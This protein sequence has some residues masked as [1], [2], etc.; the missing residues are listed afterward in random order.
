MGKLVAGVAKGDITPPAGLV[1]AGYGSR[2]A[3]ALGTHDDL[4]VVALY[5][6]DGETEAALLTV[7]LLAADSAGV[8]RIREAASRASGVLPEKIMVAFSH[9]HGAP[10]TLL[11]G[12]ESDDPLV[13]TY[14]DMV[15]YKLAGALAE[16]KRAATP[17]RIGYGRQSCTVG[18]NRR[19]MR[20]DGKVVLGVNRE[21]P[22]RPWADVIRFDAEGAARPLAVLCSYAA[23]GAT[24][25]G[26]NLFYT[27][28]YM[29]YAKATIEQLLPGATALFAAGCCGDINPYPRRTFASCTDNGL[30]V[31]CAATQ[32]A[33]AIESLQEVHRLVVAQRAFEWRVQDPPPLGEARA[34]LAVSEESAAAELAKA[35]QAAN[36]PA[37]DEKHGIEF[38]TFRRLKHARQLVAGL[39]AGT[40]DLAVRLECQAIAMGDVAIVGLPGEIFVRI[41]EAIMER[42]PFA[43]TIVTSLTNGSA[44]YLP[45]ADQVPLGGYE[46]ESARAHRYGLTI[47]DSSDQ[48]AIDAAVAVLQDCYAARG[49]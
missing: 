18:V 44:G 34:T 19:E 21:G 15:V 35:R 16:A 42:S 36:D 14:T 38:W 37:L 48:V 33:L 8:A 26:D 9:T 13:V 32:A 27:A 24:L 2:T 7:D 25:S 22:T 39:E 17:V 46:I 29:G 5:L 12:M 41:G 6:S 47:V 3:P 4:H 11:Y 43:H 45:T 1:Q 40:L 10:H 28:D 23:H 30:R 31:G 49:A 20:A